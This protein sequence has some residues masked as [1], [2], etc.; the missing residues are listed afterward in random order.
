MAD[1][2]VH[3]LNEIRARMFQLPNKDI[4]RIL[5]KALGAGARVVA[6]EVR[7]LAPVDTG[8]IK[9]NVVSKMGPRRKRGSADS[10]FI[11]GVLHGRTNTNAT[12]AGGRKRKVTAYDKRGQDPFYYRFQDLGYSA[13]GR[14]KAQGRNARR[15]RAAA[16]RKIPG[17]RFL[18]RGLESSASR[19]LQ[20]V[21][22][23]M[24]TELDKLQ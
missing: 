1:I 14:R 4:K 7:S 19:A 12:T 23:V 2:K 6:A 10:R 18:Q 21:Q 13:V 9:R 22:Q 5:N 8:A 15:E 3:G 20:K 24:V 16:G 11:V 17:K